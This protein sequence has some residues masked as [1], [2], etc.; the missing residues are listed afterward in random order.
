MEGYRYRFSLKSAW[1][2]SM[3]GLYG[4]RRVAFGGVG[5]EL[6]ATTMRCRIDL[7]GWPTADADR[8]WSDRRPRGLC[9][10]LTGFG[11][12]LARLVDNPANV[13]LVVPVS[14]PDA[15]QRREPN[16]HYTTARGSGFVSARTMHLDGGR[17]DVIL[18]PAWL[19]PLSDTEKQSDAMED[20]RR[21]VVH[22]ARQVVMARRG[23]GF[24]RYGAGDEPN[25]TDR[26]LGYA[27]AQLCDEHRAEWQAEQ[28]TTP[29]STTVEDVA[30]VLEE[31]GAQIAAAHD[32]YQAAP[33][34]PDALQ[35]LA[36]GVLGSCNHYWTALAYWTAHH[37]RSNSSFDDIGDE[38]AA[39][40]LWKRYVGDTWS[41]LQDGLDGLPVEDLTTDSEI[42]A[43][44]MRQ[45]RDALRESLQTIGFRYTDE[46]AGPAFYITRFDFPAT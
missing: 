24:D 7:E 39:L 2:P 44:A 45:V 25:V 20:V 38:I 31:L 13:A 16:A 19:Y 21:T 8:L 41:R 29:R 12:L 11:E 5:T 4:C 14:M 18:K 9:N 37:R 6:A 15:V 3:P 33:A 46:Q 30:A 43:A 32:A 26:E 17:S 28:L 36:V 1:R 22:E 27:A 35:R 40:P 34:S 42:L 23:S 10:A